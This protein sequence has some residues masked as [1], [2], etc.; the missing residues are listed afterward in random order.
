MQ[1]CCTKYKLPTDAYFSL[2]KILTSPY[3]YCVRTR[4]S[5]WHKQRKAEQLYPRNAQAMESSSQGKAQTMVSSLN[6]GQAMQSWG[7]RILRNVDSRGSVAIRHLRATRFAILQVSSDVI[8]GQVG[9]LQ[10]RRELITGWRSFAA[11]RRW[12]RDVAVR[13]GCG[14]VAFG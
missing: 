8:E 11:W 4:R 10:G 9:N 7:N 1:N 2:W 3:R 5:D 14:G 6:Q 12:R 13:W